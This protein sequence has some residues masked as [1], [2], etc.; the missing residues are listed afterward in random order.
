MLHVSS[1]ELSEGLL[2][3]G[4]STMTQGKLYQQISDPLIGEGLV[5][6]D[7]GQR[8]EVILD[9]AK[10]DFPMAPFPSEKLAFWDIV[11]KEGPPPKLTP[12]QTKELLNMM[13]E[14][15]KWVDLWFGGT[16]P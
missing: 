13:I 4:E 6:T 5:L 12:R 11:I 14:V 1:E 16:N 2:V 7:I 10:A 8:I 9:E 3:Q 15:S